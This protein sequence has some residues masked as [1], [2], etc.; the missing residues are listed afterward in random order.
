MYF[1]SQ[2]EWQDG[3]DSAPSQ[4]DIR[5]YHRVFECDERRNYIS[6]MSVHCTRR[7]RAFDAP[8][9]V[10]ECADEVRTAST[11]HDHRSHTFTINKEKYINDRSINQ[12]KIIIKPLK[13]KKNIETLT[14][15]GFIFAFEI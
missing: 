10:A 1:Y 13:S 3:L 6:L 11:T 7:I 15:Y 8:A 14:W 12:N 9:G 2:F 5:Q 4:D